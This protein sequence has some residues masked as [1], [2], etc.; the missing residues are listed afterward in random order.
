MKYSLTIER[1][2]YDPIF[3]DGI[4]TWVGV[5]DYLK[6]KLDSNTIRVHVYKWSNDNKRLGYA[7]IHMGNIAKVA[8]T[9]RD[10]DILSTK[11]IKNKPIFVW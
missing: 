3:V 4:M 9:L 7:H 1:I 11:K 8:Y 5:T 10:K 6:K 2:N